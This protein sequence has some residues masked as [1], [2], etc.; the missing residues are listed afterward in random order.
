VNLMRREG[1]LRSDLYEDIEVASVDS[2]QGRE[3]DYIILSCVR[4]NE[5]QG[6]GFL[7]DPRR[8]NVA[9]TRAKYGLVVLGNPLVLSKQPLWNN[10]LCHFKQNSCL[11]EGPLLH[12]KQSMVE[13]HQPRKSSN[14]YYNTYYH[15]PAVETTVLNS[16]YEDY[17][18]GFPMSNNA[19]KSNHKKKRKKQRQKTQGEH[20]DDFFT[21]NSGSQNY[22]QYTQEYKFSDDAF[23]GTFTQDEF[24]Q[25]FDFSQGFATQDAFGSQ[26]GFSQNYPTQDAYESQN[27]GYGDDSFS[28]SFSTQDAFGSQGGFSQ[29][30]FG[31]F[32]LNSK[33]LKTRTIWTMER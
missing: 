6:I 25:D 23:G 20:E 13:F 17:F 2:F 28:E 4:S 10:L 16:M 14:H 15:R 1:P 22:S 8:L 9:L 32:W 33:L 11:I 19:N 31:F 24:S 26:G 21:Q 27:G 30:G 5:H 29:N 18:S 12:L 3:K 7:N